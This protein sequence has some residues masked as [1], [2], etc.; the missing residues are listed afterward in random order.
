MGAKLPKEFDG[1]NVTSF[2]EAMEA[3]FPT[4]STTLD[5][6]GKIGLVAGNSNEMVRM[7][8]RQIEK[9]DAN[10]IEKPHATPSAPT[11]DEFKADLKRMFADCD[12]P[13]V[14]AAH[15]FNRANQGA[16]IE[17]GGVEK[18]LN[19]LE[20]IYIKL[21]NK[22]K[23]DDHEAIMAMLDGLQMPEL[24][25]MLR[26][27]TENYETR[28]FYFPG[29]NKPLP[30]IKM[31]QRVRSELQRKGASKQL[32]VASHALA[33]TASAN[34]KYESS[35][36]H[37]YRERPTIPSDTESERSAPVMKT[38]EEPYRRG[39][40]AQDPLV[41]MLTDKLSGMTLML[42]EQQ[43]AI[44]EL[45]NQSHGNRA[46]TSSTDRGVTFTCY[47]C[48]EMGH[49]NRSCPKLK[50]MQ[51]A[52]WPI[53]L[54]D[55][56]FVLVD[57]AGNEVKIPN[58]MKYEGGFF[59]L[60]VKEFPQYRIVKEGGSGTVRV[61][62]AGTVSAGRWPGVPEKHHDYLDLVEKHAGRER[63]EQDAKAY[64]LQ[65]EMELQ[66]KEE[67]SVK[68]K[69][70]KGVD[71]DALVESHLGKTDYEAAGVKEA[72]QAA[73]MLAAKCEIAKIGLRERFQD[74]T[75]N[76]SVKVLKAVYDEMPEQEKQGAVR[77]L[78]NI[79]EELQGGASSKEGKSLNFNIDDLLGRN[80]VQA[81][82]KGPAGGGFRIEDLLRG[83]DEMEI[84][85][86]VVEAPRMEKEAPMRPGVEMMRSKEDVIIG[87]THKEAEEF[88]ARK[89]YLIIPVNLPARV[90]RVWLYEGRDHPR[91]KMDKVLT[92]GK[93][94]APRTAVPELTDE[95]N[96][97]R[98][99]DGLWAYKV[100]AFDL[101]EP[102]YT[103]RELKER[104]GIVNPGKEYEFL[105]VEIL[106]QRS[107]SVGWI[108]SV[109]IAKLGRRR[110]LV[111]PKAKGKAEKDQ[112]N[113][114]ILE[115]V[116]KATL[117]AVI[118]I[119]LND[120]LGVAPDIRRQFKRM[121]LEGPESGVVRRVTFG[122]DDEWDD[123]DEITE[124]E[125]GEK[126]EV[127]Q[128]VQEKGKDKLVNEE[129]PTDVLLAC[130]AGLAE[131]VL[132]MAQEYDFRKIHLP[133][134]VERVWVL[135]MGEQQVVRYVWVI[136]EAHQPGEIEAFEG[137][138]SFG[139][140]A[141]NEGKV[142]ENFAYPI[143]GLS[144]LKKPI[145]AR[146]IEG[147]L[148]AQSQDGWAILDTDKAKREL[149]VNGSH[150]FGVKAR[151]QVEED[152]VS[153][154]TV[155]GRCLAISASEIGST[156]I[157][158]RCMRATV[159]EREMDEDTETVSEDEEVELEVAEEEHRRRGKRLQERRQ[160]VLRRRDPS[161]RQEP[162]RWNERTM[163]MTTPSMERVKALDPEN[164]LEFSIPNDDGSEISLVRL[165]VAKELEARGLKIIWNFRFLMTGAGGHTSCLHGIIPRLPLYLN[166][167]LFEIVANVA[168]DNSPFDI[169][170]GA[171][172][173]TDYLLA[174]KRDTDGNMYLKL[175]NFDGF[176][177]VMLGVEARWARRRKLN[178]N[179]V[180]E[181]E[182][183]DRQSRLLHQAVESGKI[184]FEDF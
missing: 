52:G 50:A 39:S 27:N 64:R 96:R 131:R 3:Y 123:G 139:I 142:G 36:F 65:H 158:G 93:R 101:M 153:V 81:A 58:A 48:G 150:V 9:S 126:V 19:D 100:S 4:H 127:K 166:G 59:G 110:Q 182:E 86:P 91:A 18:Y 104:Y 144:R 165:S 148:G 87:V 22:N 174:T 43:K 17:T 16:S 118:S 137:D 109:E 45:R 29:T 119:P 79:L 71:K 115:K 85:E 13:I 145:M 105:P 76:T 46:R 38:S 30:Y 25:S 149:R 147:R 94:Y 112:I 8:I 120:L 82:P 49:Y 72:L 51:E 31:V 69:Q 140:K 111:K 28:Q 136:G 103:G 53:E 7:V 24:S 14:S 179:Y 114:R 106:K 108:D 160:E 92:L 172:A 146:D 129:G 40:S 102:S 95:D 12:T 116:Y 75:G 155:S 171:N 68:N 20:S 37:Q 41:Q 62:K 152:E 89:P 164:G 47:G 90:K 97:R 168:P 135:E 124:V 122:E 133:A 130:S 167:V 121:E 125:G 183:A 134:S 157:T 83:A 11:W 161:I 169:L 98:N 177:V 99:L 15:F 159:T 156:C 56:K 84:D 54:R 154:N 151:D 5:D 70:G 107:K 113:Q 73:G 138:G 181:Q 66:E 170:W 61:I 175:T 77:V 128:S 32:Q 141:F 44:Q 33:T 80:N 67:I 23:I 180:G 74:F 163:L 63:A 132:L 178:D 21:A 1:N 78:Q 88:A 26:A 184:K 173:N 6:K 35:A 2:L 162:E 34:K 117:N 55:N 57:T 143:L 60:L 176:Q 42:Q 10:Y